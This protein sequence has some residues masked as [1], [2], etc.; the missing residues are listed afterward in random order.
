M[1]LTSEGGK[2]GDAWRS[3]ESVTSPM[4]L[5]TTPMRRIAT[6]HRQMTMRRIFLKVKNFVAEILDGEKGER[7]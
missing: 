5:M 1:L 4:P 7:K 6:I 2:G 3:I